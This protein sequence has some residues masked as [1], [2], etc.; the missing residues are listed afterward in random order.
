MRAYD[1]FEPS[2]A[3]P[4]GHTI[5]DVLR[6]KGIDKET[7]A[8]AAGERLEVIEDLLAGRAKITKKL[9]QTLSEHVG[10][11]ESFW[12]SRESQYQ[13]DLTRRRLLVDNDVTAW[14]SEIPVT[15][16]INL[17]WVPIV[18]RPVDRLAAILAY[19]GVDS[20]DGWRDSYRGLA[21]AVSFRTSP[22]F[23]SHLGAVLAWLRKGQILT[24]G[25]TTR[26]LSVHRLVELLPEMRALT[27]ER[28]PEKFVP[29]L[30][31]L[32]NE[33]GVAFAVAATPKRCR[34]SGATWIT[35]AGTG[36][37]LMSYRYKTDDQ[38]W[39]TF[40]H[41]M[42]HLVLHS[43][44]SLFLEDG[45][46]IRTS[47][48]VEAN[49]FA[50]RVLIPDEWKAVLESADKSH[51]GVIRLAREIGVSPGIV[52]GQMQHSDLLPVTWL[53]KLK[54]RLDWPAIL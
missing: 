6:H 38:F 9:A 16:L 20:V 47:D 39:F 44:R 1:V 19:F 50:G 43:E 53:N 22:I 32:C 4:P 11:N 51:K 27:R 5:A 40:F 17:K 12:L 15:E 48:E 54:R 35:T 24:E 18:Q 8:D 25:Q 36:M 13:D 31:A 33:A 28:S 21:S 49:D 10:A 29:P 37:C 34:A 41:E 3:S 2:W 7:L 52:V 46:E 14:L 45:D 26:P 23:G 30:R 42:G